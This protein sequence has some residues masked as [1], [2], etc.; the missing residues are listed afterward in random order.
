MLG[1]GIFITRYTRKAFLEYQQGELMAAARIIG[2]AILPVLQTQTDPQTL[3]E[4]L[5]H[6]A[7]LVGMRITVV[8]V[9]GFVIGDSEADASQMENH[10][11]RPEIAQALAQGQAT[12][13][14]TSETLGVAM[15]YLAIAI[16]SEKQPL[17]VM[18]VAF[19]LQKVEADIDRLQ[20]TILIIMVLASILTIFLAAVLAEKTVRP[21]KDLTKAV[22]EISAGN[23]SKG[24][25]IS[26][27]TVNTHDEI[28]KLSRAFNRMA[29]NL[30]TQI[31][32]L[33]NERMK[34]SAVLQEM[35]DGVFIIDNQGK[36]NLINLAAERMF[37]APAANSLGMHFAEVVR[38]HQLIE[39]WK[40][41][42]ETGE[43]QGASVEINDKQL[44]LFVTATPLGKTSPGRVLLLVQN[45]T[46]LHQTERTRR[47]F[48]S[49][50][51]HELRTPLAS[52][53]ALTETLQ[54]GALNDPPA[55][56]RFLQRMEQ[57]VDALSLMV[58]EL[59]ELSRIESGQVP[60]NYQATS[61]CTLITQAVERL[62]LQAERAGLTINIDC[63]PDLPP[64]HADFTRL[65]Q[66]LVNLIH[67]AIKFTPEEGTI[68][69][70]AQLDEINQ[71]KAAVLFSV[72]DTGIGIPTGE[73]L[74]IFERFYKTD[75]SRSGGGTGLGLAIARHI[76][77]AH[78]GKIWAESEEGKG[79][80]FY[81]NIPIAQ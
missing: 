54:E 74:R 13:I 22:D 55:A 17:G 76:V 9:T 69:V 20:Q 29:E 67:N 10:L 5:K 63:P 80:T 72:Q 40:H 23:I 38:Q 33:E 41:C 51:S 56:Q 66:V 68:T 70:R 21:L 31:N 77:E 59:L 61:P 30:N 1:L 50:I 81:F 42:K 34:L 36:I 75:R 58:S 8:D 27:P 47:D 46:R 12:S 60:F 53:K 64:I 7:D 19:P 52:L 25:T 4:S 57:E 15:M 11:N 18:R 48:I 65:E 43:A 73:L 26:Y 44:S 62:R 16:P 3:D 6:Y 24:L 49:N 71:K 28:G 39:L 37:S 45:L 78:G 2:D 14:R 35:S 79:S 32:D